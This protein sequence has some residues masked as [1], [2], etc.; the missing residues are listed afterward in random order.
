MRTEMERQLMHFLVGMGTI[1]MLFMFSRP[2]TAGAV[3]FVLLAGTLMINARLQNVRIPFVEWFVKRFERKNILF[4]G[5]G[6]A[7]YAAGALIPLVFL[8]NF[9]QIAACIL[10]L[11]VGDG[12]STLVG[13]G[14]RHKLP[15][16]K[17]KTLEGALAFFIGALP[18]VFFIGILGIPLAAVA[19]VV[20]TIDLRMDDNLTVPIACTIFFLVFA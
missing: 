7:C 20:E 17:K 2:F 19:A 10:I 15:Y 12:L 13:I 16:N 14:G 11:A 9:N 6:S 5:F 18:S 1:T 8:T 3:F 4:P